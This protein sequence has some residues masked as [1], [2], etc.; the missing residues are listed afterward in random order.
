MKIIVSGGSGFL[1]SHVADSLSDLGHDVVVFDLKPSRYLRKD[2]TMVVGD[3]CDPDA[4]MEATRDCGAI[5][6]FA[7]VADIDYA[8]HSPRQTIDVNVMGALNMLEA[9]RENGCQRFVLASS[10]YV[11]SDKGSFYRTSKRAAEL[12]AQDFEERY[13]LSYTILRF[14]SLYGPR[15]DQSNGVFRMLTQA[16][17]E[18]AIEYKGTGD[19][20]REYIHVFDAAEASAAILS[21][22][23]KNEIIHL[24]GRERMTTKE[25]MSMIAE[26]LGTDVSIKFGDGR[27][28]GHYTQTPYSYSP[29]LGKQLVRDKYIDIG[30]GLLN[31]IEELGSKNQPEAAGRPV[32]APMTQKD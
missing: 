15:S 5:Y 7:A 2:Q 3:I 17:S 22:G 4:V 10:I 1:G 29:K 23:Y 11:Y 20:I 8:L 13:G 14:G 18:N 12:L 9:A 21:D 6:H 28:T 24:I 26:I 30:L 32:S 25:I 16:L 31:L 19:E 27:M